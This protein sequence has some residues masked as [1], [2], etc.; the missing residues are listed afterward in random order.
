MSA[1]EKVVGHE[2]TPEEA[3]T[4]CSCGERCGNDHSSRDGDIRCEHWHAVHL[5]SLQECTHDDS[6]DGHV[7][8]DPDPVVSL[9]GT[10]PEAES[11]AEFE[12][13]RNP[14]KPVAAQEPIV[15]PEMALA[16]KMANELMAAGLLDC[17]VLEAAKMIAP[18]LR[19][20]EP[21]APPKLHGTRNLR[22][23]I[24]NDPDLD[25]EAG[26]CESGNETEHKHAP[27]ADKSAAEPIAPEPPSG[28][29]RIVERMRED[30]RLCADGE[31]PGATNSLN[32]WAKEIEIHLAAASPIAQSAPEMCQH[33]I[34]IRTCPVCHLDGFRSEIAAQSAPASAE[35]KCEHRPEMKVFVHRGPLHD[36][37][38]RCDLVCRAGSVCIGCLEAE[39]STLRERLAK[40]E[41]QS[42]PAS[43][44]VSKSLERRLTLQGVPKEAMPIIAANE[45]LRDENA[46]LRERLRKAEEVAREYGHVGAMKENGTCIAAKGSCIAC[47]L[48]AALGSAPAQGEKDPKA[49]L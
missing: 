44:Y 19:A 17:T 39:L 10:P 13:D 46:T 31:W 34:P 42:S 35:A 38:E 30:A 48:L 36:W 29:R 24:M 40:Y 7:H 49:E 2:W 6:D 22:E 37:S 20:A 43:A 4:C 12:L 32:F 25:C 27:S 5:A 45:K 15:P 21:I 9:Q 8:T 3:S 41:S 11:R 33:Q 26:R 16:K 1:A 28:L 23:R 14:P 47:K 18:N